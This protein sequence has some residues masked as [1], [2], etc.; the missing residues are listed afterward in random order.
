[1]LGPESRENNNHE[2]VKKKKKRIVPANTTASVR[3]Y[4]V[5]KLLSKKP[6]ERL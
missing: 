3:F 4:R 2:E 1:M 5:T 6:N